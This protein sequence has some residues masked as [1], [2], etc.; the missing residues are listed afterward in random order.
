[1][2]KPNRGRGRGGASRGGYYTP[3]AP[4]K[5]RVRVPS[6]EQDDDDGEVEVDPELLLDSLLACLTK[7]ES[8]L[9]RFVSH[10]LKIPALQN[11]IAQLVMGS[12]DPTAST[13]GDS[14]ESATSGDGTIKENI[15]KGFIDTIQELTKA[16]NELKTE[17]KSSTQRC[18]DLEQYSRRN[19]IIIS[20]IPVSEVT[21]T[22][23]QVVN[24]LNAYS[25]ELISHNDI[26][27]CHRL[28]KS[29][30]KKSPG[31]R[32][33]DIIVKFI[34]H[35]AKAAILSKEPME[36]LRSD[37]NGREDASKLYVREDLTKKRGTIL[38]K[39]RQLK[40]ASLIKDAFSRDGAITI[41]M[42]PAKPSDRDYY[43]RITSEDELKTFCSKHKLDVNE[44]CL[45]IKKKDS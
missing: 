42:A 23:T 2:V 13:S 30:T 37:N 5:K 33:P 3:Q 29:N 14:S 9:D 35:K 22:E 6:D 32:P 18:D 36:K 12:I 4:T 28:Q 40:K 39:A 16:V 38:Y 7:K 10:L 8:L 1:M 26:D 34:S 25:G 41:R 31:Q 44:K 24:M 21:N 20:G 19:N 11:K 43:Y 27:R 15:T 45:P 17:L